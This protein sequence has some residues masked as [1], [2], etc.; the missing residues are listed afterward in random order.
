[1]SVTYTSAT[2]IDE[3]LAGTFPASDP[4]A[5]T[6]GI[7][8]PAPEANVPRQ[9]DDAVQRETHGTDRAGTDD[10]DRRRGAGADAESRGAA[11]PSR[12]AGHTTGASGIREAGDAR[13]AS[14]IDVIDVS[15]HGPSDRTFAQALGALAGAAGLVVL[16]PAAIAAAGAVVLAG[17]RGWL[18]VVQSLVALIP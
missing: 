18:T 1:M 14:G 5:W 16:I 7:A 3:V 8:R 9:R 15:R 2:T 4:P 17:V 12:V 13:A 6:P 11:T 10:A